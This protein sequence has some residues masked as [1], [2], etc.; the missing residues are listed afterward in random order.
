M[1]AYSADF[2]GR[3]ADAAAGPIGSKAWVESR[4]KRFAGE[5]LPL[6]APEIARLQERIKEEA[7]AAT[8]PQTLRAFG[9]YDEPALG[10][11]GRIGQIADFDDSPEFA[12]LDRAPKIIE[13]R[14]AERIYNAICSDECGIVID[15][16]LMARKQHEK[17]VLRAQSHA[18][19][20]KLELAK[21]QAYRT[22]EWSLWVYGVHS[23][24]VEIMPQFRRVAFIPS[25]AAAI[26]EPFVRA[27]EHF[28]QTNLWCRFWTFSN[29]P[30]CRLKDLRAN[31]KRLNRRLSRLNDQDFMKDSGVRLVF[32]SIELG[33]IEQSRDGG[34]LDPKS[35]A[36]ERDEK[37][38]LCFHPH[39]HCCVEMTKGRLG[40]PEW[41]ALLKRVWE[42]WG[43]HWD[44]GGTI[45]SVREAVKYVTKPNEIQHLSPD[46][47]K[48]LFEALSRCKLVQPMGRLREEIKAREEAGQTLIRE[49]TD[50]GFVWRVVGNWNR[51]VPTSA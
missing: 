35:G 31:I 8:R 42:Y 33:T 19:A 37:G 30:R 39:A 49:R 28:L 43:D 27:L 24:E 14:E 17:A 2:M 44:D 40:S 48:Q 41:S 6:S 23:G 4:A 32:R 46:E 45:R 50:D 7:S 13:R 15:P 51:R 3:I 47:T 11:D 29:G 18:I 36:L 9:N 1:T 5:N 20:R 21:V 12:P 22:G 26:R 10:A 38:N 25:V 16:D 34:K